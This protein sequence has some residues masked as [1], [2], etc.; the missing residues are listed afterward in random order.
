M[1][2]ELIVSTFQSPRALRLSLLSLLGQERK[3]DSIAVA[4]D[5]SEPET[6]NLIKAFASDHGDLNI[7]HVWHEDQGFRKWVILNKAIATSDADYLIFTDGDC[8]MSPGFI[9]RHLG[10]AKPG[11]YCCGS[12]IRLPEAASSGVTEQDVAQKRVYSRDWL[13]RSDALD[14]TTTW[15]KTAPLPKRVLS[16][17]EII[18][19]VRRTFSGCNASAFRDAIMAVNGFDETMVWGGGDKEFGIRL[20]NSGVRGRHLRFTAPVAHLHHPR[21]YRD[22]AAVRRHREII[23]ET[24]SSSK[25]WTDSGIRQHLTL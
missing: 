22:S 5:G 9:A 8:M 20:R 13:R 23:R 25:T 18:W 2:S 12:L 10:L 21:D 3:P 11:R 14:R 24:R 16:G 17:M 6:A 15:L 19:P 4:D 7:R 1:K